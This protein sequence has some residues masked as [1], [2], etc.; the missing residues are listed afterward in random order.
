MDRFT[1]SL[2]GR[3]EGYGI[4]I[5]VKGSANIPFD[6]GLYQYFNNRDQVKIKSGFKNQGQ[7]QNQIN[8]SDLSLNLLS[9]VDFFPHRDVTEGDPRFRLPNIEKTWSGGDKLLFSGWAI[10]SYDP[11]WRHALIQNNI[12][13]GSDRHIEAPLE[14]ILSAA[15]FD[16]FNYSA[17][18][19]YLENKIPQSMFDDLPKS[20]AVDDPQELRNLKELWLEVGEKGELISFKII[21]V[22]S[23]PALK[24]IV[25]LL[26][27]S[28]FNVVHE[29][30]FNDL[31]Y[32]MESETGKKIERTKHIELIDYKEP[33]NNDIRDLLDELISCLPEDI[34][35]IT[36]TSD[37]YIV[38][39][40]Q[41]LPESWKSVCLENKELWEQAILDEI[42]QVEMISS[43][44]IRID[45]HTIS[46]GQ[47]SKYENK[48]PFDGANIYIQR[49]QLVDIRKALTGL[50]QG[51][52]PIFILGSLYEGALKRF[53]FL[54]SA[55]DSLK[56]LLCFGWI[57][58]I[59]YLIYF[60]LIT[61]LDHRRNYYGILMAN[62]VNRN[63]LG[64]ILFIQICVALISGFVMACVFIEAAIFF[65][66]CFFL[67]TEAASI[68]RRT[69]GLGEIQLLPHLWNIGG[70]VFQVFMITFVFSIMT[71]LGI[72]LYSFY[73]KPLP[74]D[75]IK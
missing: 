64:W 67:Y 16:K 29:I 21:W 31:N 10:T 43:D 38:K 15:R 42:I 9:E 36:E 52:K 45:Q 17:Y 70:S 46:I 58:F 66:N 72:F 33:R 25:F 8:A 65:T 75:L 30:N 22:D 48:S 69:L 56:N 57:I 39:F 23:F 11:L 73:R 2:L 1:D 55:L 68:G 63:W 13:P 74:M 4:P 51:D 14:I 3:I 34:A 12:T 24:D 49:H 18:R 41:P 53:E 40:S 35:D 20:L 32:Y 27:L 54:V 50:L 47:Q 6:I 19:N 61:V 28:T 71:Y 26:P 62:G 5:W 60:N 37:D 44:S 59:I 7:E